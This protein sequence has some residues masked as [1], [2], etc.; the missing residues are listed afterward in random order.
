[1]KARSYDKFWNQ[2]GLRVSGF[3]DIPLVVPSDAPL[4]HDT[5]EAKYVTQYLEDYVDSH[6]YNG[7]SLRSRILFKHAVRNV[8][9][10]DSEWIIHAE[11]S[12]GS[13]QI[14]RAL[15]LVVATGHT[16]I[17]NMPLLPNQN[18][19]NGHILHHKDF[20][21]AS[22]SFLAD[23]NCKNIAV[24]G[25]GKSAVDMVYESIKKGKNV[26]WIIRKSGEGPALF[27]PAPGRGRYRNSIESSATRYKASFSP[28]SFMPDFWLR[29]LFHRSAYG[30]N[31]MA[32]MVESINEHCRAPAEYQTR[33][34][35]LPG[36]R[37][38][39]F[40]TS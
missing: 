34:L 7:V 15:K 6:I 28:S 4:F 24:L 14:F 12:T 22:R 23:P 37:N 17:P 21:K 19:F 38:L 27:F 40:T 11:I 9:K 10:R 29:R 35:A 39:D 25:G 31:Y 32:K 5:F 36:F 30:M 2:S 1:L 3:S 18:E 33:E 16:S 20:G 26:S 8:E 13:Q